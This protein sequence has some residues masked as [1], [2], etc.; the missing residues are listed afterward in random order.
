MGSS[1]PAKYTNEDTA[2]MMQALAQ[3]APDAIRAMNSVA[4]HTAQ[5]EFNISREF[6]P[7]DAALQ[8]EL[9]AKYGPGMNAI[10]SQINEQNLIA[11]RGA[12]VNAID[13]YGNQLVTQADALQRQVDPE[14]YKSRALIGQSLD[15]YL[16]ARSPDTLTPT[17][18]AQIQRGI[19]ATGGMATPGALQTVKNASTFGAAGNQKWKD[20]GDA[21]ARASS[22]LPTLKSGIS[23]FEVA[24][25]RPLNSN[26]GESRVQNIQQTSPTSAMD[27]TM[28]FANNALNQIGANQRG[29]VNK[30]T[31]VM[32]N[33]VKGAG[34][35]GSIFGGGR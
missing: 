18:M 20:Y 29:Q 8:Q 26:S 4:P 13:K 19:G 34:A 33:I 31:S 21:V 22:V 25:G 24:T 10:G 15:R 12:D 17:E 28:G 27:S 5:T 35:F 32:D 16:G 7:Q 23:A 6:A 11:A 1:G 2:S 3:Y 9:Y 14:A 30:Q